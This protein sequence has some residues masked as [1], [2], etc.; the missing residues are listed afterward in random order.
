M[1]SS[2]RDR[3]KLECESRKACW[4]PGVSSG[5]NSIFEHRL[6]LSAPSHR[7]PLVDEMSETQCSRGH[8]MRMSNGARR[9]LSVSTQFCLF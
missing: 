8:Y 3:V 9:Q 7:L 1:Y 6:L 4:E 2:S 5:E